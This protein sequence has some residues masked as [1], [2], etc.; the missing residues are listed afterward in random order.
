MISTIDSPTGP[1]PVVGR[2]VIPIEQI[3]LQDEIGQGEFGVVMHGLYTN[4]IGQKVVILPTTVFYVILVR[5][6]NRTPVA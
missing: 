6:D 2:R 3:S 4:D 1:P 5:K